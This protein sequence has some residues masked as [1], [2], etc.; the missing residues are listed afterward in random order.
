MTTLP[1]NL[2]SLRQRIGRKLLE[3][4]DTCRDFGLRTMTRHTLIVHDP[5]NP[6]MSITV[7]NDAT[8]LPLIMRQT[9]QHPPEAFGWL[10]GKIRPNPEGDYQPPDH[11]AIV[12]FDHYSNKWRTHYG[13]IRGGDVIEWAQLPDL[14]ETFQDAVR[15]DPTMSAEDKAYWLKEEE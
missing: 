6:N 8:C 3:I 4:D 7:S 13:T 9:A 1:P 12:A 11:Y 14:R 5:K 2:E 15:N 10:L